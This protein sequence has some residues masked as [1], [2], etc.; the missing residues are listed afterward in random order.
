MKLRVFHTLKVGFLLGV[1]SALL[2]L[3]LYSSQTAARNG[4]SQTF[5]NL[6]L[7]LTEEEEERTVREIPETDF[8]LDH[9]ATAKLN[10]KVIA[11]N[12]PLHILL[13][14][15]DYPQSLRKPPRHS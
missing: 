12:F 8:Y 10:E 3:A 4:L 13:T 9:L 15:Q 6:S 5:F 14:A 2:S 11:V 1:I 7:E